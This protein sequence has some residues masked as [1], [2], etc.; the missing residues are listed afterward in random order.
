M[1]VY[2]YLAEQTAYT[3]LRP[4]FRAKE[5]PT[6]L[7]R[8]AYLS[9]SNWELDRESTDFPNAP[10]G[11]GQEFS[12]DSHPHLQLER[13]MVSIPRVEPGDQAWWHADIIHA[14][15]SQH[16]GKGPSAV[17]YIPAVPVTRINA[18]Y[19]RD[20]RRCFEMKMPP[21]DFP[22]GEGE[23]T[24]DGTGTP[25]D[26]VGDVARRAMGLE[27]WPVQGGAGEKRVRE[28]ANEVL[29]F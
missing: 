21:P 13:T 26:I 16:R 14:V 8:E 19:V 29:G 12:D 4:L 6:T 17:M 10:Q 11:R 2:P 27:A 24:F 3:L 25:H 1:R 18:E 7:S 23:K 20:Q 9:A 22:G 15:E 28:I 5:A